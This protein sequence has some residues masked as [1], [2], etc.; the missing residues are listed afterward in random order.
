MEYIVMIFFT[1]ITTIGTLYLGACALV[2]WITLLGMI[3][4]IK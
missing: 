3:G 1:V 4:V 2:G